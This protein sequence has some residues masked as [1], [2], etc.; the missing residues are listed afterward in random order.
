MEWEP[1][2]PKRP[3]PPLPSNLAE[4][5]DA[6]YLYD[7]QRCGLCVSDLKQLGYRQVA[8]LLEIH[9]YYADA[10]ANYEDDDKARKAEA[11]FWG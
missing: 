7:C 9:A 5:C 8:D 6:R 1:R 4:A 10:A 11:A 3:L 2:E